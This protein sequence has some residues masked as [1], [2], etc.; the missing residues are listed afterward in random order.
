LAPPKY[1]SAGEIEKTAA[2]AML[3]A[4]AWDYWLARAGFPGR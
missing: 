1:L 2:I 3:L 4:G